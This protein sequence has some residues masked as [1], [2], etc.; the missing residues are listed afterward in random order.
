MTNEYNMRDIN[1]SEI[2]AEAKRKR[3]ER[4]SQVSKDKLR[5]EAISRM[6]TCF[7]GAISSIEKHL[8]FLF[9]SDD[10][11]ELFQELRKEILDNGNDQIRKFDKELGVY[12]VKFKQY[13]LE[14]KMGE[15]YDG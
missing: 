12:D 15:D 2:R 6:K 11:K 8:D 4:L 9:V 13:K 14:L 3:E 10:G 7:I 5:D 1:I